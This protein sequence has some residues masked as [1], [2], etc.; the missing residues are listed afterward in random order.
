MARTVHLCVLPV[1]LRLQPGLELPTAPA[2]PSFNP[3]K[4]S[5]PLY[6]AVIR[7]AEIPKLN[8]DPAPENCPLLTFLR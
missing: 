5:I 8:L 2:A 4:S 1:G 3:P 6:H 7:S